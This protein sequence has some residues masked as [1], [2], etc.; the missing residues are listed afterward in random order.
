MCPINHGRRRFCLILL[1]ITCPSSRLANHPSNAAP[2]GH[3]VEARPP[4][5]MTP[6]SILLATDAVPPQSS[7]VGNLQDV[8]CDG[9]LQPGLTSTTVRYLIEILHSK[10]VQGTSHPKAVLMLTNDGSVGYWAPS[11]VASPLFP[12]PD[13][14]CRG[15]PW[16]CAAVPNYDHA[17][18]HR[19]T[20][21]SRAGP[22]RKRS[23][24]ALARTGWIVHDRRSRTAAIVHGYLSGYPP[25]S[26]FV[27]PRA[28]AVAGTGH[29]VASRT[30]PA[31][32]PT[33]K[34]GSP[35]TRSTA[36]LRRPAATSSTPPTT[37]GWRSSPSLA[38]TNR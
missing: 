7:D 17:S 19:R 23:E 12:P 26:W 22:A 37:Q 16:Q 15:P 32:F 8:T 21:D 35:V 4:A 2:A 11:R 13:H 20:P 24:A 10:T 31:S 6:M 18:P 1:S 33:S 29:R 36:S 14:D 34:D 27:G 38:V 3:G 30:D 9:I 28:S 5:T 25:S